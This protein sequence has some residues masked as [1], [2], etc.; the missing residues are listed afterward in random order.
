MLL[1]DFLPP[2]KVGVV[3][4][5]TQLASSLDWER[6]LCRDRRRVFKGCPSGM[7]GDSGVGGGSDMTTDVEVSVSTEEVAV[8]TTDVSSVT[9]GTSLDLSE[10]RTASG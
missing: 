5:R 4:W 10:A 6:D 2:G 9:L 1:R 3:R 8:S 7:I